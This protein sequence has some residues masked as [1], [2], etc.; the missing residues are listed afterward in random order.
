MGLSRL[1]ISDYRALRVR[2]AARLRVDTLSDAWLQ[3][4]DLVVNILLGSDQTLLNTFD[5]LFSLD[6]ELKVLR[7]HLLP[8]ALTVQLEVSGPLDEL[9][10]DH[11]KLASCVVL[12]VNV[13]YVVRLP[14]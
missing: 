3:A 6:L 13:Q 2:L 10:V 11:S 12:L 14:I 4:Y 5:N 7:K 8:V 1:A 9:L